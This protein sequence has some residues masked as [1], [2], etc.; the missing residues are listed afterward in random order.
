MN[1][2]RERL[3][4]AVLRL[5]DT[6][7]N[8]RPD[9]GRI[10]NHLRMIE[11]VRDIDVNYLTSMI[12]IRYDETRISLDEIRKQMDPKGRRGP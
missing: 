11:G 8:E 5:P 9:S 10:A 1:Q 12:T 3:A 7:S 4:I 6:E 2:R